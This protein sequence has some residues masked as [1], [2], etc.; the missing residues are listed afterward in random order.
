MGFWLVA[1]IFLF[2]VFPPADSSMI[3]L[4]NGGYEDIVIAIHPGLPEDA[5]IIEKIKVKSLL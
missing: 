2:Q 3:K 4:N 1:V 5:K